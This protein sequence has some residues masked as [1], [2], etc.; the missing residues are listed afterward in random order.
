MVIELVGTSEVNIEDAINNAISQ[1]AKS[2]G[3]W[4]GMKYWKLVGL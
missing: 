3:S 2:M 4:I 1:A